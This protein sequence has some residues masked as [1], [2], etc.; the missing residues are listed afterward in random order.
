[1]SVEISGPAEENAI[2][3]ANI[4]G[5]YSAR[6][7]VTRWVSRRLVSATF[8]AIAKVASR[9]ARPELM[10]PAV[11]R[12]LHW[13]GS[14][15]ALFGVIFVALRLRDYSAGLD[16][17]R[18]NT[19]T[20]LAITGLVLLCAIANLILALAWWHL[21]GQF[22]ARVSRRWAMRTYG[23]SY[24]AKYVPGS[25]VHLAGRQAMGMAAGV[26]GW[27]VARSS[28]WEHG[29]ISVAGGMFAILSLPLLVPGLLVV[30]SAGLFVIALGIVVGLFSHLIGRRVSRAF[31]LYVAFLAISGLVFATLIALV[32]FI[33]EIS[34]DK[35]FLFCGA[36]VLAWLIGL[37]TPGAPAGIGI[38]E[39][40][41]L[42]LLQGEVSE[43]DLVLAVLLARI[44]T[45][46]GDMITYI[47]AMTIKSD[48]QG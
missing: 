46:G 35:W 28:L 3:A 26:P 11:R 45:V 12:A 21:L 4:Y 25:I 5:K 14:G 34:F 2:A 18:L 37:V 6:K 38:R 15:L 32:G 20:W 23:V 39:L 13:A 30:I 19:A 47:G 7:P 31:A 42:F 29:L 27:A 43:T 48:N 9:A 41:L 24:L 22:D 8:G 33:H 16:F 44:V 1:M 36:Y 10:S 40:V 17:S